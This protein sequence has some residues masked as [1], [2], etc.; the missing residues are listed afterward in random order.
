MAKKRKFKNK[1]Q[2]TA[3]QKLSYH[4]HRLESGNLS[5]KQRSYSR[6]WLNGYRDEHY[7]SNLRGVKSEIRARRNNK[8][9]FGAYD[10]QLLAYRNGLQA[11][12]DM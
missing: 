5:D 8:V 4:L 7:K 6:E 10:I 1:K 2:Y 9:P 12:N 3:E 11:R